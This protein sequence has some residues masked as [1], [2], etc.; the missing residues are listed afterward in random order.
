MN[1]KTLFVYWS[2]SPVVRALCEASGHGDVEVAEI[3]EAVPR[4]AFWQATVGLSRTVSGRGTRVEALPMDLAAYDSVV[5]GASAA[6]W[7]LPNA[8]NGFLHQHSLRGLEAYGLLFG[9]GFGGVRDVLRQRI[10]LAGGNCRGVVCVPEQELRRNLC[11]VKTLLRAK[12][13]V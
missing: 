12:H 5:V 4:G 6:A 8:V 9:G 13:L 1:A 7:H 2:N 10:A 3:R 11:D